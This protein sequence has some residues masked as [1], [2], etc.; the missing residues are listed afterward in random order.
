MSKSHLEAKLLGRGVRRKYFHRF[1]RTRKR[2]FGSLKSRKCSYSLN[3]R[4][5]SGGDACRGHTRSHPEHDGQDLRGRWYY[6]GDG[7]GE[8][9]AA[10]LFFNK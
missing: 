6:A 10:G 7:M 2:A 4:R 3:T 1:H 8:Q 9:V 5:M